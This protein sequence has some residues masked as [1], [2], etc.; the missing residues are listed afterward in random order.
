MT[1]SP[2]H[3]GNNN[4][5]GVL[6]NAKE[7]HFTAQN[8]N[9]KFEKTPIRKLDLAS[10]GSPIFSEIN[11]WSSDQVLMVETPV[12]RLSYGSISRPSER[13]RSIQEDL[14]VLREDE[15]MSIQDFDR[16]EQS[17]SN[18]KSG[19][20]RSLSKSQEST[21]RL[22]HLAISANE[23]IRTKPLPLKERSFMN[24]NQPQQTDSPGP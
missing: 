6:D 21:K 7:Q 4:Y 19:E 8:S 16:E 13:T 3:G 11:H 20:G 22:Y 2:C 24:P 15:E 10:L 1:E 17:M 14:S 12:P 5:Q 9:P 18:M 23:L